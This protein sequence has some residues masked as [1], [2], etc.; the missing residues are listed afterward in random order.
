MLNR[1]AFAVR[2]RLAVALMLI[3]GAACVPWSRPARADD[4]A[5]FQ[6]V[7]S[8]QV[9]AFRRDDWTTAFGFASPGVRAQFGSVDRFRDMVM[10]GYRAVAR[11]Q[12]FEYEAATVVD[13]RPTQPVF[14]VGPDGIAHR[15]LYFM[16]QQ[17]DGTWRIGGCVLLPVADRTT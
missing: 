17:P 16:E 14:V 13:G 4:G 6:A 9:E 11:P 15:A 7:I 3:L 1:P 10:G 2:L 5:A 12:V 8:A